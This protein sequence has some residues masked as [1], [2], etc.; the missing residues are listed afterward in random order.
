MNKIL[1]IKKR[2]DSRIRSAHMKWNGSLWKAGLIMLLL[3]LFPLQVV[4]AKNNNL[5]DPDINA[6]SETPEPE[7]LTEDG[8]DEYTFSQ[9]GFEETSLIGPFDTTSVSVGLPPEWDLLPGSQIIVNYRVY[10]HGLEITDNIESLLMGHLEVAFNDEFVG[11][12]YLDSTEQKSQ[13]I[14]L[15]YNAMVALREDG[16]KRIDL[17]LVSEESCQ[18][19]F[20]INVVVESSSILSLKHE[21]GDLPLDF[22]Q[23]PRPIYQESSLVPSSALVVMPDQPSEEELQTILEVAAGLGSWTD[24]ELI[25]DYSTVSDLNDILLSENHLIF[26]GKP[27]GFPF[28]EDLSLPVSAM[29][30]KFQSDDVKTDDGILQL[31]ISPWNAAKALL[32]VSGETDEAVIKAGQALSYGQ[33]LSVQR[34]DLAIIAEVNPLALSGT[35]E[36]ERTFANLGYENRSLKRIGTNYAEYR[37]SIP[38]GQIP[39]IES[40][41]KIFFNHSAFMEYDRSGLVVTLNDILVG[42]VRFSDENTQISEV[43]FS[44]PRN[45][46]HSG[47]NRLMLRVDMTPLDIC[48]DINTTSVW[49]MIFD[50]SLIYL[51][52][53]PASISNLQN[54]EA[55]LDQFPDFLGV[56]NVFS[57]TAFMFS[58]KNSTDW[59]V[60]ARIAYSLGD[61]LE[62]LPQFKVIDN[63]EENLEYLSD[64]HIFLIGRPSDFP[65]LYSLEESLPAPFAEGS[66]L[67]IEKNS[68]VIYRIP[69]GTSVGYLELLP[70]PWSEDSSA[71]IVTGNSNEGLS[72]AGDAL[73]ISKLRNN[74]IGDFAVISGEQVLAVDTRFPISTEMLNIETE[75]VL[76]EG[77]EMP[78][79]QPPD[80]EFTGKPAWIVPGIIIN[81]ALIVLVLVYIVLSSWIRYRNTQRLKA[82]RIQDGEHDE[83]G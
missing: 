44:L 70:S 34:P 16:R 43:E 62:R 66:E 3:V 52:L 77:M 33:I 67:A 60:G 75:P 31:Q 46:L 28:I 45:I 56:Q 1:I 18:N 14:P 73:T 2:T 53:E 65:L 37:F 21:V 63:P 12:I 38:P 64:T 30:G 24:G 17:T 35:I 58:G 13:I 55:T 15:T 6:Q 49:T 29:D 79:E 61:Q 4:Q 22:S 20:L 57:K 8:F 74:L 83:N 69:F 59:A 32:L 42:S 82:F 51:P 48:S 9:M 54:P 27:T 80:L 81:S 19:D 25:L 39:S 78:V 72:W 41:T 50:E 71:I 40:Y 5:Q 68:R 23:F 7:V 47:E 76:D 36:T 10:I 26:V 11:T